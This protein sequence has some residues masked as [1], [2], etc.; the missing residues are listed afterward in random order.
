MA[1]FLPK[2][3]S[4]SDDEP[5]DEPTAKAVKKQKLKFKEIFDQ[6]KLAYIIENKDLFKGKM[7]IYN[8]DYDPFLLPERYLKKSK[9]GEYVATYEQ[10]GNKAFGRYFAKGGLSL[11][12][13]SREI[14]HT[15]AGAFYNDID[16]VNAH[17]VILLHIC[18]GKSISCKILDK[19]VKNREKYINSVIKKNK[20]KTPDDVKKTILSLLNGGYCD[21]EELANKPEWLVEFKAEVDGIHSSICS[22]MKEEFKEHTKTSKKNFN[23][24]A[25]FMNKLLCDFENN[26]L[27]KMI[28]FY[29]IKEMDTAVLCFDGIMLPVGESCRLTECEEYIRETMNIS[30]KLKIKDMT[31]DFNINPT[32]RFDPHTFNWSMTA[33]STHDILFEDM[34]N[35]SFSDETVARAFF[36]CVNKNIIVVNNDGDGYQWSEKHMLWETKTAKELMRNIP[37]LLDVYFA[38]IIEEIKDYIDKSGETG[39]YELEKYWCQKN[40]DMVAYRKRLKS[41]R[42]LKDVFFIASVDLI[43]VDFPLHLNVAHHLFPTL[44]GKV[45]DLKTGIERN[46]TRED[47]FSFE[48][49]VSL[50]EP[51]F[52]NVNRYMSSVFCDNFELIEYMK[53]RMG[54]FLTGETLREID[55]WHGEGR[56]AKSTTCDILHRILG[57]GQFYNTINKAVFIENPKTHQAGGQTHT[58]HLVPLMGIRLGMCSEI[59]KGDE[60]NTTM[61]KGLSGGDPIT[62]RKPYSSKE[63]TF[64]SHAKL[65]LMTNPKPQFDFEDKALIDRLRYIPFMAR[66]VECPDDN[67]KNEYLADKDFI[68]ELMTQSQINQFFTYFVEG[69][70]QFYNRGRKLIA[71]PIVLAD[72][73]KSVQ[74]CDRVGRFVSE[75]C[76]IKLDVDKTDVGEWT[77]SLSSLQCRFSEWLSSNGDSD[78]KRGE[79]SNGLKNIGLKQKK[80]SNIQ[81]IGIRMYIDNE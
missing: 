76:E 10:S 51:Q 45:V 48:C 35:E 63:E 21:Y 61:L 19:Y 16:M 27:M 60:F 14:R 80:S 69:T 29:N 34:L 73:M 15:I 1:E 54:V 33:D 46:R 36:S 37:Q 3:L 30:I 12:S 4:D 42:G 18:R 6:H 40:K 68:E 32:K 70:K 58:S 7:R 77:V 22:L 17:P 24:K 47:M 5:V 53:E 43:N 59:K 75:C 9:D 56:N 20:N 41:S 2:N 65:V 57:V 11:Q 55:V 25:S 31:E 38:K 74:E 44:N 79:L 26:I 13:F 71:P 28:E 66:F 50:V 67:K 81:F 23:V 64:V 72:K 8:D 39:N 52:D 62:Y 49:P 78:V